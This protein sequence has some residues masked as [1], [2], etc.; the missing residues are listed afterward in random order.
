MARLKTPPAGRSP[1]GASI[2]CVAPGLTWQRLSAAFVVALCV[3]S[4]ASA[5]TS[6][7]TVGRIVGNIDGIS[8]DGDQVFISGWACQQGQK[9]SILVHVFADHS[10]YDKPAGTFV[11][12]PSL[13]PAKTAREASTDS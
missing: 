6:S 1:S 3:A 9:K 4:P 12:P 5:Q 13:R 7:R 11:V 2:R 10:V 8:Q